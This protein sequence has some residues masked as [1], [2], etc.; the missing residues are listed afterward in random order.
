MNSLTPDQRDCPLTACIRYK[1]K[2]ALVQVLQTPDINVNLSLFRKQ[3]PLQLAVQYGDVDDV[4]RLIRKGAD[5]HDTDDIG[6][7]ALSLALASNQEN[8]AQI[9]RTESRDINILQ[10]I[11]QDSKGGQGQ[12]QSGILMTLF[13]QDISGVNKLYDDDMISPLQLAVRLGRVHIIKVLLTI[14]NADVNM[15]NIKGKK[16]YHPLISHQS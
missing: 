10:C 2:E 4:L 11:R 12:T 1:Q 16:M 5:R 15:S 8:I 14:G 6:N 3:T 9:L 7:T 13:L